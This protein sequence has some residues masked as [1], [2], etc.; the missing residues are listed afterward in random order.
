MKK[1]IYLI[2]IITLLLA[3]SGLFAQNK[4]I[5]IVVLGSSTAEGTGPHNPAKAWVYQYR[6]HV[7]E[8][9]PNSI[10]DNLAVGGYTTYDV[11]PTEF[12]APANRPASNSNYNITKALSL[13]PDV[14]IINLPTNDATNNYSTAEQLSNFRLL[15]QT[16]ADQ[17]VPVYVTTTQPR[18][19][20]QSQRQNLMDVRDSIF[21]IFGD[22]A[23]DFWSEIANEDGMVNEFYDSGDGVHLN[24]SAHTILTNRVI[25]SNVLEHARFDENTDMI[26]IDFGTN[27]SGEGWNNFTIGTE[28]TS[29]ELINYQNN[30]TGITAT[31]HDVFTGVNTSGTQSANDSLDLPASATSDSFFG[32]VAE[33]SGY[34]EPTGGITL[35]GLDKNTFYS[36]EL[37]A[38]RMDVS[39]NRETMYE[40]IGNNTDTVYLNPSNNTNISVFASNIEASSEGQIIINVGPGPNNSNSSQFYFIGAI[41]IISK[42]QAQQYDSNGTVMIDFGIN[43]TAGNW[44][45]ISD[46]K[47]E[48]VYPELINTEGNKSSM[49]LWVHD[50]FTGINETGTVNPDSTLGF[51]PNASSDSFFGNTVIF[52]GYTEP[53]G[54]ITLE[55]LDPASI[56]TFTFFASRDEVSDNRETSYT[57][58]G[59]TSYTTTLDPSSNHSEVAMLK[60]IKPSSEGIITIDVGPGANNNNSNQFF[61]FGIL[62]VDYC[63][64]T[65]DYDPDGTVMV[66][67]GSKNS[68][69]N[70]NNISDYKGEEEF[71]NLINA[72]G[73]HSSIELWVHDAF[74]GINEAGTT[75]PDT[76][77][78]FD[79]NATSDSFFGNTTEFSGIIEP[80]GGIT[81][82][83][84]DP[85]SLYSFTFFASRSDVSDNREAQYTVIGDTIQI[86]T[87]DAS[88]NDSLTAHVESMQPASDGTI[89]IE[90]SPGANNNNDAQFYYLGLLQI[91]Y[92]KDPAK[93]FLIQAED[94]SDM[95][96]IQTQNTED[97][98]GGLNTAHVESG[99][100]LEY[101]IDVVYSGNYQIDIRHAGWPCTVDVYVDNEFQHSFDFPET[102]GWQVWQT[103]SYEIELHKGTKN[104]R[105]EF[106]CTG[107]NFNWLKLSI[108]NEIDDVVDY[109]EE[110]DE[111]EETG[112]K[113]I[114][115]NK[116]FINKIFPM[117]STNMLTIDYT[118]P[119][120]SQVKID[121]YNALGKLE[122]QLTNDFSDKG[123]HRIVWHHNQVPKGLYLLK[124]SINN[125]NEFYEETRKIIIVN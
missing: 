9:N 45:N 34:T 107:I 40:I 86:V 17:N 82:N 77:L 2:T 35:S 49:L 31:I 92:Q 18:N 120:N 37:F 10:V 63:K 36:L 69:D 13:N 123:N 54:G 30:S 20:S 68:G 88:N 113:D 116:A 119:T 104:V 27:L 70:W 26:N 122:K 44:N 22:R 114:K 5:N 39:D 38:S 33:F 111:E 125:N 23:I 42:K 64:D 28:N 72:E 12:E 79:P 83:C 89:T 43:N 57:V 75:T 8:I 16:A 74:T 6:K 58:S 80:T 109:E 101:N 29:I 1:L 3:T 71:P 46:Y 97:V 98:D 105:F 11:M 15:N 115:T 91:D 65:I 41:R 102:D 106:N 55:N 81:L 61:Y 90:V 66:D 24:D 103:T 99:D 59:K 67:F 78:A 84:L 19:I 7:Q 117:P 32:N 25:E 94:Y 93:N 124:I 85:A 51:D 100:W 48:D 52:S 96:G 121:I 14:I 110:E 56:Y 73:N 112:F 108:K 118:L 62:Q 60:N 95:S 76:T 50:A 53:T 87:L 4:V 47:G 21:A